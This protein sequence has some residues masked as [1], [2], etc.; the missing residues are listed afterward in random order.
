[1]SHSYFFYSLRRSPKLLHTGL[2]HSYQ[3]TS[4]NL[5]LPVS[6][7]SN[8]MQ[9][10][11]LSTNI[12]VV[13]HYKPS[14]INLTA[15]LNANQINNNKLVTSTSFIRTASK[16]RREF[17]KD[18]RNAASNAG[19]PYSPTDEYQPT[20]HQVNSFLINRIL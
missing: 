12:P 3:E 19:L 15:L 1:L 8:M 14:P 17:G 18:K 4:T 5:L 6:S 7:N 20:V 9:Q 2:H 16:K 13:E 10:R 11:S